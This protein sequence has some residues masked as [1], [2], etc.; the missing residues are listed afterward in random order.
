MK[1]LIFSDECGVWNEG[2]YYI[3]SWIKLTPK[4]HLL[5]KEVIFPNMKLE[6]RS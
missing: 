6:L 2:D 1:Y 4:L 5:K 3:R